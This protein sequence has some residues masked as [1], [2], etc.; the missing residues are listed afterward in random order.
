MKYEVTSPDGRKLILEGDIAPTEQELENIFAN[1]KPQDNY[2]ALDK[3]KYTLRSAGEGLTFGLGDIVAGVTNVPMNYLAGNFEN[4]VK[5]FKEGRRD[6]VNEQEAFAKEH[7]ALNFA[8]EL[9]GGLIT[10]IGGAAKGAVKALAKPTLGKMVAGGAKSGAKFGGLYAAGSG[11][12]ENPEELSV[13]NALLSTPFGM[14][15]GAFLGGALPVGI[16]G[17]VAGG[18]GIGKGATKV[19][20]YFRNIEIKKLLGANKKIVE[21]SIKEGK[22]LI[23]I[24]DQQLMDVA[25]GSNMLNSKAKQ[26]FADYGK[27]RIEG[28]HPKLV[29][30]LGEHFDPKGSHQLLDELNQETLKGSKILYDNAIYQLDKDGQ[31]L[32]DNAGRKVGKVLP[33]LEKLNKYELDYIGKV[34]DTKGLEYEVQ[35]LPQN[36]MRILNYAK[37]LMDDDI[38]T[39]INKGHNNQARIL[40]EKRA[41]FIDKIDK[42]N[43]DYKTARNF[44]ERGKRAEDALQAGKN[45]LAGERENL[46]YDFNKLTPEEKFY[47]RQGVGNK[48][49]ELSNQKT[50]GGNIFQR[51]F[52]AENRRRLKGLDI[53]NYA[54]LEKKV[55]A[56]SKAASNINSLRGGSPTTPRQEMIKRFLKRPYRMAKALAIDTVFKPFAAS[57][58]KI[59][60]AMTDP[61]FLSKLYAQ[62]EKNGGKGAGKSVIE[63]LNQ[64]GRLNNTGGVIGGVGISQI[65]KNKEEK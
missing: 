44:F 14:A 17:V 32:L 24:A 2:S 50:E 64:L 26:T 29:D 46:S 51:V 62:A 38:Q 22:P 12:T 42:A 61:V 34:Y 59:A 3:A 41:S 23:D 28:Q 36:D 6:F 30:T 25:E 10:G 33:E 45:A 11:F 27:V 55:L 43:P 58:E 37:Q 47:F 65:L 52:N 56:E 63:V 5:L 8:G 9:G 57:P 39:L 19:A 21:Q 31:F 15:G 18:K 20:D 54:D 53:K 49:E 48:L 1:Y 7:P 16:A 40:A 13:K 60:K 4:P 35:G